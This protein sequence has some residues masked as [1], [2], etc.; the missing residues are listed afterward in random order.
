MLL[1]SPVTARS[2]LLVHD[3]MNAEIRA[4]IESL[5]LEEHA[6]VVYYELDFVPG[7]VYRDGV[8][9]GAAWGGIGLLLTDTSRSPD[10]PHGRQTRYYEPF[11]ALQRFRSELL[12]RR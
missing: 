7:Y 11:A 12:A 8:C 9:H 2:V 10:Y 1:D 5:P 3:T 6:K 4:G